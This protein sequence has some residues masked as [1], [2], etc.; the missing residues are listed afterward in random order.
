[1][2]LRQIFVVKKQLDVYD[3]NLCFI[4]MSFINVWGFSSLDL[5][6]QSVFQMWNQEASVRMF[7]LSQD[8]TEKTFNCSSSFGEK[9]KTK[10]CLAELNALQFGQSPDG[11][12]VVSQTS[13][14]DLQE[15][16]ARATAG[17]L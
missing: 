9:N 16:H 7:T 1:M 13:V 14:G 4:T 15:V 17:I 2:Y 6:S 5:I 3:F 10:P 12:Q 11:G 8:V